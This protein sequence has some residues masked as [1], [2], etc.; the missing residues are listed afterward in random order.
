MSCLPV[1]RVMKKLQKTIPFFH[2]GFHIR[3]QHG[4][5]HSDTSKLAANGRADQKGPQRAEELKSQSIKS[6]RFFR[7]LWSDVHS[8]F[9]V[10]EFKSQTF[11]L[12]KNIIGHS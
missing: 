3:D 12:L 9:P 6:V 1:S 11:S 4:P 5:R 8:L 7:L 10:K 2:E